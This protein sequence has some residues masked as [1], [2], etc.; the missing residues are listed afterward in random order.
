MDGERCCGIGCPGLDPSSF[1]GG[2]S[3]DRSRPKLAFRVVL[4]YGSQ[5]SLG[6]YFQCSP[7]DT[8]IKD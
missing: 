7:G 2:A 4:A 8:N 3:H 6:K 1:E 5:R